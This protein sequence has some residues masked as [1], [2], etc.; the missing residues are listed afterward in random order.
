MSKFKE[1][2][3]LEKNKLIREYY[4]YCKPDMTYEDFEKVCETPFKHFKQTLSNEQLRDFRF[5]YLGSFKIVPGYI[6]NG[7][8]VIERRFE[9]GLINEKYYNGKKTMYL[10]YVRKFS[11]KFIKK[12][13]KKLS[14][15]ISL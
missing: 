12:H 6:V 9:K 1:E 10:N 4:N 7:L 8:E 15:W 13:V 3:Y 14:K 11:E 2:T 5:P